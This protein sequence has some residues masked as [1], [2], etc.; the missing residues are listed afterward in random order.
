MSYINTTGKALGPIKVSTIWLN[1]VY[2]ESGFIKDTQGNATT[3]VSYNDFLNFSYD[4]TGENLAMLRVKT[5]D[6]DADGNAVATVNFVT[7]WNAASGTA[8]L[9]NF[10]KKDRVDSLE[11][12]VKINEQNIA[13]LITTTSTHTTQINSL[14]QKD[15]ELGNAISVNTQNIAINKKDIQ[16]NKSS[17]DK[18]NSQFNDPYPDGLILICGY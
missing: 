16:A 12:Y 1:G 9:D 5:P 18:L 14:I 11:N 4:K 17:I 3:E 13:N 6:Y 15:T 7:G 8:N 10:V 2:K